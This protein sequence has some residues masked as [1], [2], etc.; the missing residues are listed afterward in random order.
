MLSKGKRREERVK[1]ALPVVMEDAI[2]ITSDVS[3]SGVFFETEA[4]MSVGNSIRFTVEFDSPRGKMHLNCVGRI[5]R[6]ETRNS[7]S[8]VAVKITSSQMELGS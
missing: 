2:G 1:T 4:S 6:T 8:G 7:R 5:V 3:A